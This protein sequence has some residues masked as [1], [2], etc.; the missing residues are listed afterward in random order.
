M[1]KLSVFSGLA[2]L[3]SLGLFLSCQSKA[4]IA[5]EIS[6]L[7][8]SPQ[9]VSEMRVWVDRIQRIAESPSLNANN[10]SA[11]LEPVLADLSRANPSILKWQSNNM[12][13]LKAE[14]SD[15]LKTLFEARLKLRSRVPE[16]VKK[17]EQD[18]C[19]RSIR[20]FLVFV[21]LAEEMMLESMV[22]YKLF[23]DQDADG[24]ESAFR[25]PFPAT[26]V[27]PKY[28]KLEFKAG[29]ILLDRG[30]SAMSAQ[31]ARI[32]DVEHLFSH[33]AILGEDPQGN[34]Y[35]IETTVQDEVGVIPI[36]KYWEDNADSRMAILR[37][38]DQ[39]IAQKA[40]RFIYDYVKGK[41]KA[42]KY[43]FRMNDRDPS[44]MFCAEVPQFAFRQVTGGK[45]ALP[46]FKSDISKFEKMASYNWVR[47]MGILEKRAFAPA[48]MDV[49]PRFDYVAEYRYVAELRSRRMD[50]AVLTSMYN[51]MLEKNYYFTNDLG[52]GTVANL[53]FAISRIFPN[54]GHVPS[55]IPKGTI[56]A[57]LVFDRVYEQIMAFLK[58]REEEYFARNGFPMS[59]GQMLVVTEEFRAKDCARYQQELTEMPRERSFRGMMHIN[60]TSKKACPEQGLFFGQ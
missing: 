23:P 47:D 54:N 22:R 17:G 26:L 39:R 12:N 59:F 37:Y 34:L 45:L 25:G 21:R 10:C 29:D 43:D 53:G 18:P 3:S 16:L 52:D 9:S 31:I 36:K 58:P 49:D 28:G 55:N 5:N 27:N 46:M 24:E 50:D 30:D 19:L 8:R 35:V 42:I 40:A 7:D 48:D 11:Q 13:N 20:R 44:E 15:W 57:S 1:S 6:H 32:G 33:A 4:P 38:P 51:W 60:F 41:S 56:R 2:V 14:S